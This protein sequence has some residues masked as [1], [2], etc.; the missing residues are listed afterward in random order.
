MS[1]GPE[2]FPRNPEDYVDDDYYEDAKREWDNNERRIEE[3][4][5]NIYEDV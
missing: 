4:G 1:R 2:P 3:G 5:I